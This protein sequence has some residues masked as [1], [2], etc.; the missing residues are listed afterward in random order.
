MHVPLGVCDCELVTSKKQD[1]SEPYGIRPFSQVHVVS[2][3][4]IWTTT[5]LSTVRVR[6][7][8]EPGSYV[9]CHVQR[10]ARRL[11]CH[12]LHVATRG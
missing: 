8:F 3:S 2:A 11:V 10:V 12:V 6:I 7:D 9:A 1:P 4:Q 5:A